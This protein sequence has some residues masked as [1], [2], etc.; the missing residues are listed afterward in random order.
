MQ[1]QTNSGPLQVLKG[2]REWAFVFVLCST[3]LFMQIPLGYTLVPLSIISE[4]FHQV[5][6]ENA[7]RMNWH[8]AA[9]SLTVG[10]FILV[11]GRLGDIYGSK[12]ILVFGWV[13][14]GVWSIV[15]GCSA[16]TGSAAFFDVSRA[17]Q[18]IGPAL[19]LPNALAIAGRTYPP[20][21][22]KNI[23]FSMIAMC[24]P[25][26]GVTGCL[27]GSALAQY[28]WWPWAPWIFGILC[29]FIAI[30]ALVAIPQ[31]R[32]TF[33]DDGP[34]TFDWLGTIFGVGG[35]VLLNVSWNQAPIDGWSNPYVYI[36]LILGF[37]FLAVFVWVEKRAAQPIMDI[38]IF[39]GYVMGILLNTALSWSS[40]G[41]WFYYIFQFVQ[42]L[43]GVSVME[44]ALE[45]IA[46]GVS[47]MIAPIFTAWA[48]PRVPHS[49]LM[50]MSS[51]A[52]FLGCL[53]LALAPVEQSFWFNTFW[54]LVIMPWGYA[55][56]CIPI[57]CGGSVADK[58]T[59]TDISFPVSTVFISDSVPEEHQ[60]ISAS[61]INTIINYSM[62]LGLGIAGTAEVAV[63]RASSTNSL[64]EGQ[65]AAQYTSLGLAGLGLMC[66]ILLSYFQRK[67]E[68]D[69]QGY[70]FSNRQ[71]ASRLCDILDLTAVHLAP[72]QR[73]DVDQNNGTPSCEYLKNSPQG[74]PNTAGAD[75]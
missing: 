51:S 61:L 53:L 72:G 57:F 14:L 41:I 1:L 33:A 34:K 50:V 74:T 46:T 31:Y 42:Q 4:T 44:S 65:R 43:R 30:L 63:T 6:T 11:A 71:E 15:C 12:N 70:N 2:P 21:Q 17:F 38:S 3:Q 8:V 67:K 28:V 45:F 23:V 39:N 49:W 10:S 19:L 48:L 47:G 62:A 9:F 60:G 24:A 59:R 69:T 5:G 56:Q 26:G 37:I 66:S 27:V 54:S 36:L 29:F 40:F 58:H 16:F 18:G 25:L 13:W 32:V 52:F 20:G 75:S 55:S 64:L 7:A 68:T 73:L 35:L 22:K